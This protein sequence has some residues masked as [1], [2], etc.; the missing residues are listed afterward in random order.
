MFLYNFVV[1]KQSTWLSPNFYSLSISFEGKT[2][3]LKKQFFFA[4]RAIFL[5]IKKHDSKIEH[6][7]Y[8]KNNATVYK[9]YKRLNYF[10]I[11][12]F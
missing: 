2:V 1:T 12:V 7:I 4:F 6:T 5:F 10:W 11:Q 9:N 8:S 3:N